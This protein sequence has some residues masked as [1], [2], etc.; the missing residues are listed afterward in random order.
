MAKI[1][2]LT[3]LD[4][5]DGTETIPVVK[6][7]RTMRMMLGALARAMVPFLVNYYKG[8]RGDPGGNV[9]ALQSYTIAQLTPPTIGA[10]TSLVRFADYGGDGHGG[11]HA[12]CATKADATT[13]AKYPRSVIRSDD[14]RYFARVRTVPSVIEFGSRPDGSD[15]IAIWREAIDWCTDQGVNELFVPNVGSDPG[16]YFSDTLHIDN[17]ITLRGS[18]TGRSGANRSKSVMRFAEGKSGIIVH[19]AATSPRSGQSGGDGS[20]LLG[21]KTIGG[22]NDFAVKTACIQLRGRAEI[23]NH[24]GEYFGHGVLARASGG[25]GGATEG[26]VNLSIVHDSSFAAGR[27]NAIDIGLGDANCIAVIDSEGIGF[28]GWGINGTNFLQCYF[29]NFHTVQN[30]TFAGRRGGTFAAVNY[31][32]GGQYYFF[33]ADAYA[34]PADLVANAPTL[35]NNTYWIMVYKAANP[36]Y[37]IWGTGDTNYAPG[38]PFMIAGPGK[39]VSLYSESDQPPAQ[40]KGSGWIDGGTHAA[41]VVGNGT[42]TSSRFGMLESARGFVSNDD[43]A[44]RNV[45]LAPGGAGPGNILEWFDAVNFPAAGKIIQGDKVL[46]FRHGNA[47][48]D[49]NRWMRL[50][51]PN[52]PTSPMHVEMFRLL[53]SGATYAGNDAAV[54]AALKQ[55]ALYKRADGLVGWRM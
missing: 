41:G 14:G 33:V 20:R 6:G 13:M 15:Q 42:Y 5:A 23:G 37:P 31:A 19:T 39:A 3:I 18:G 22:Q 24:I 8:D 44:G 10:G 1:S 7:G 12:S 43:A 49:I 38:G 11:F 36:S 55:N 4:A 21:L 27:G 35:A 45:A 46:E 48:G 29:H 2:A 30:G 47:D 9:M 25:S 32:I 16:F 17:A 51:A 52:H 54:A 26:N 53:L 34:K 50:F 40:V 28:N